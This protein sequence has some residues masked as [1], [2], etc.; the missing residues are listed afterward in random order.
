MPIGI[1]IGLRQPAPQRPQRY[2]QVANDAELSFRQ[3][4]ANL[5][6]IDVEMDQAPGLRRKPGR[7]SRD[8]VVVAGAQ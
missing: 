4:L 2:L 3:Y 8:A 5:F 7:V 1:F 6:R